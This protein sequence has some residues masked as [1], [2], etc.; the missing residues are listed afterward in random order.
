M[1]INDELMRAKPKPEHLSA[2]YAAQFSDPSVA[3]AYYTRPKNPT[4]VF[5]ILETLMPQRPRAVLELGCGTGD[6]SFE[7]ARR[8]DHLDAVEPSRAMLAEARKRSGADR[9][10][11]HWH[12]ASAE[13]FQ[14]ERTYSLVCAGESLHWMEWEIVFPKVATALA[15]S[16]VLAIANRELE[17]PWNKEILELILLI[18]RTRSFGAMTS[19]Q[20]SPNVACSRSW[21]ERP[22]HPF[23]FHK[24]SM[25]TSNRFIRGTGFRESGWTRMRL[26][27]STQPSGESFQNI[28]QTDAFTV[29]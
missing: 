20:N 13:E 16:G 7:L 15:G 12:L 24:R 28:R 23:R 11:L 1:G 14:I 18:Q 3:R 2:E 5:E 26:L 4:E 19:S 9:P 10:N 22:R 25:T 8:V 17:C 21:D 27:D 6:L 29:L